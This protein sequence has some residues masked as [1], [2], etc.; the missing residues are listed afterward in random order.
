MKECESGHCSTE[1]PRHKSSSCDC[2]CGCNSGCTCGCAE[3]G[4]CRCGGSCGGNKA[5]EFLAVAHHELLKEKMK[6]AFEARIG[7]KMDK[8]A[9]LVVETALVYMKDK[10]AE[11]QSR[12]RFEDKLME[13]F[14]AD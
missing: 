11:R 14:R 10:M 6:A 13:I 12:E 3:G 7:K 9:N 4:V 2:G 8:V 5:D 1:S